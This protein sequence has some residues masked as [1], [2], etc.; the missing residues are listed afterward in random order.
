MQG[1]ECGLGK[2]TVGKQQKKRG[3]A[4]EKKEEEEKDIPVS[5]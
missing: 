4:I 3:I 1:E 5:P 2:R